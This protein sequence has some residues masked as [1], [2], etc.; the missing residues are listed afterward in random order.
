MTVY[1][2]T[3]ASRVAS[4]SFDRLVQYCAMASTSSSRSGWSA[5]GSTSL[6]VFDDDVEAVSK[7]QPCPWKL[8]HELFYK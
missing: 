5:D 2:R 7:S 6:D 8:E 1:R 4:M 3:V